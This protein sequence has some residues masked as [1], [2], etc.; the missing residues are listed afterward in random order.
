M[1]QLVSD[2]RIPGIHPADRQMVPGAGLIIAGLTSA[3]LWV[4][5]AAVVA[6]A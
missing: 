5:I 2:D 3:V 4:A 1:S 6:F